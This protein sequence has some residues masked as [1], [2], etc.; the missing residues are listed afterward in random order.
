MDKY[1]QHNFV[2]EEHDCCNIC[3][4]FTNLLERHGYNN[5]IILNDA[6]T[7]KGQMAVIK[8]KFNTI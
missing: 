3:T 4:I 1:F 2:E 7:F 5:L 6:L 8:C